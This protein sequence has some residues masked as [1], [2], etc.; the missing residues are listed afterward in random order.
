MKKIFSFAIIFCVAFSISACGSS[1][2][3]KIHTLVFGTNPKLGDYTKD[4]YLIPKSI[5]GSD[6]NNFTCKIL[7]KSSRYGEKEE[8]ALDVKFYEIEGLNNNPILCVET[9]TGFGGILNFSDT[10]ISNSPDTLF[11]KIYEKAVDYL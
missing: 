5:K 11:K 1:E 8:Y 4:Y 10:R 2:P 9:D 7:V 6:K 3:V